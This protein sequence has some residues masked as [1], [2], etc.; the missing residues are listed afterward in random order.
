[1]VVAV[2]VQASIGVFMIAF[3]RLVPSRLMQ[4]HSIGLDGDAL[5]HRHRVLRRGGRACEFAGI[6]FVFMLVPMLL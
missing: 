5:E 2:V 3:G 4:G 6:A 1:V